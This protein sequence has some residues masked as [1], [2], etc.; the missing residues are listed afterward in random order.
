MADNAGIRTGSDATVRADDVGGILY[1]VVK[2]DWGGD[3]ATIPATGDA[4]NGMD[5]DVTRVIPGTIATALGKAED[6]AHASGDTGVFALGVRNSAG[7]TLT[8]TDGDYSP[9]ATDLTGALYIAGLGSTAGVTGIYPGSGATQL[10]KLEDAAASSSDVGV[11]VLAVRRDTM[12]PAAGSD[13]DYIEFQANANGQLRVEAGNAAAHDAAIAGNPVRLAG[14]AVTADYTSVATGDTADL[15]TTLG[16][17]VIN[18][19][20]AIPENLVSGLTT[21]MTATTSTSLLAAPAANLRNYITHIIAQNSHA[22]V[23]TWVNIQDGSGGTSFYTIYCAAAGGGA[24]IEL[25]APLRQPTT[26]TA[27][28]CVNV[29]TG[30]NT[31]VSASGFKAP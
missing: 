25:P 31:R 15:I 24:S 2:L 11:F 7:A 22:T 17:K 26:A 27:V 9:I 1:Q 10:G 12:S 16:G 28:F 23:G 29:T 3:G 6:A 8:S 20:Y 19:P 30:A 21:D 14:R 4:T 5:V 18:H 13:G